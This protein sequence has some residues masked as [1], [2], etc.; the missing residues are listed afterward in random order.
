M[1]TL[2]NAVK[3][4]YGE[5]KV[6][7][8]AVIVV[9][10]LILPFLGF[11]KST[12]RIMCRIL[13][14]CTLA[15]SLNMIN[16][17]SGQTCIGQAG[18]FCIGA[19]TMAILSTRFGISFWILLPLGGIMAML[20]GLIVS[21]PT[22][23]LKGIYLSIITMGASEV[24]RIVALNWESLTGGS[25]GI[26]DIPRP[27]AGGFLVD[28]PMK[29]YYLFLILAVIFLF[30]S[31][32]VIRSRAGRAWMSIREDELAAKALSVQTSYYKA[33]NFMYGAFWAGICGA[34]YAPYL[35]YI[36][37][38]VFSLDEGFNILSMVIIGG[39]GTLAGP[40]VGSALVNFLTEILRPVGTWRFV[41]YALL[42]IIMMW[43]RPQGLV[44]ASDSILAGGR[45][46][47]KSK[48]KK[49][50]KESA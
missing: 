21:I 36:D 48:S 49:A 31:S 44:G 25:F 5:H 30:I 47:M 50:A 34:A 14:Y 29:F 41:T 33:S 20:V 23:R 42:I 43:L 19:Y 8:L 3:K 45:I 16:G 38:T 26:K 27:S 6:L 1:N 13:M 15:G 12:I 18:F 9:L 2:I 40:I 32:R 22:L 39:Q 35:Q 37:S 10:L 4:V 11:K 17:Y 46:K 28:S 7:F 24:I